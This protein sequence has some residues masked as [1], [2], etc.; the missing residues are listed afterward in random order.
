MGK[1]KKVQISIPEEQYDELEKRWKSYGYPSLATAGKVLLLGN[2]GE[3]LRELRKIERNISES[4]KLFAKN[5]ERKKDI[6]KTHTQ[7]STT[8][9]PKTST[10]DSATKKVGSGSGKNYS[11]DI[12]KVERQLEVWFEN[13]HI[14]AQSFEKAKGIRVWT[15]EKGKKHRAVWE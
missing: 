10:Q 13:G 12:E 15:D 8:K 7:E 4:E 6:Q 1:M 11:R 3:H 9:R 5:E 2:T 14:T